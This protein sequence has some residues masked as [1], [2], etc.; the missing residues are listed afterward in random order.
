MENLIK[1]EPSKWWQKEINPLFSFIFLIVSLFFVFGMG[2]LFMKQ[3]LEI[4]SEI[5]TK[6]ELFNKNC[7]NQSETL[8]WEDEDIDIVLP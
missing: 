5:S 7:R 8:N 4:W 2:A 6:E 3:Y 1:E